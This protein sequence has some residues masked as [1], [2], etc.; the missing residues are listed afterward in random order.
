MFKENLEGLIQ[1]IIAKIAECETPG[2]RVFYMRILR[3]LI[4][5][6]DSLSQVGYFNG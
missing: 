6:Q 3:N 5:V 2:Q 4:D 1:E